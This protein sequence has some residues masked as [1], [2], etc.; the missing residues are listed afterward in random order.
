M[1]KILLKRGNSSAVNNYIGEI[2]EIIIDSTNK[3]VVVQ[4]GNTKGGVVV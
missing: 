3:T 1:S 2:G 4:D